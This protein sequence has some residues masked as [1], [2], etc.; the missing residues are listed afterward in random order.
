MT[1]VGGADKEN[2]GQ[3]VM[4]APLPSAQTEL[5]ARRFM[6]FADLQRQKRKWV[7]LSRLA[8]HYA[9]M[10]S[11]DGLETLADLW[12]SRG[13]SALLA[14]IRSGFFTSS[15]QS[16]FPER[17]ARLQLLYLHPS[18]SPAR[19]TTDWL[20]TLLVVV[21]GAGPKV[22]LANTVAC[23]W[24]PAQLAAA[25]CEAHDLPQLHE[26]PGR[27]E[28][29][30]ALVVAAGLQYRAMGYSLRKAAHL[31]IEDHPEQ[32]GQSLMVSDESEIDRIRRKIRDAERSGAR[33][34]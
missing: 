1:I 34:H 4:D 23:C 22:S 28:K 32:F 31:A 8:L 17:G 5:R 20:E 6:A 10:Q 30:D 26:K 24:I 18:I 3:T 7:R 29:E 9:E 21:D 16:K 2:C 13:Y 33:H 11:P 27:K 15:I 14:D 12:I 19:M 25:W